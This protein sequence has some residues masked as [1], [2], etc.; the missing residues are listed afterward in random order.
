DPERFASVAFS[1]GGE[2]LAAT[3]GRTVRIWETTTRRPL[4]TLNGHEDAFMQVV[5]SPDGR[6]LAT[7]SRDRSVRIW[8]PSTGESLLA[9]RGHTSAVSGVSF[10][11]DG[12]RLASVGAAPIQS[13]R[14]LAEVKLWD[15]LTGQEILSLSG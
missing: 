10:S 2:Q 12:Y 15:T 7:A 8:N 14:M 5:Y 9:L 3:E 1:P 4:L 6:L 13:G 11:P